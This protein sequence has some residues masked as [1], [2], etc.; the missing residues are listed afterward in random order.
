MPYLKKFKIY[1]FCV[2]MMMPCVINYLVFSSIQA[3]NFTTGSVWLFVLLL[4]T[5]EI[6]LYLTSSGKFASHPYKIPAYPD[7]RR[8]FLLH[9]PEI[10]IQVTVH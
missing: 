7:S 1:N 8:I 5:H 3:D 10:E 2:L 6:Y 4:A 9:L